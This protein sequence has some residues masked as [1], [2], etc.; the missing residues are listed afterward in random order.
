MCVCARARLPWAHERRVYIHIYTKHNNILCTCVC[1]TKGYLG[2]TSGGSAPVS[3]HICEAFSCR[4]DES[5]TDTLQPPACVHVLSVCVHTYVKYVYIYVC[6]CMYICVCVY[7]YM[8]YIY[9]YIHVIY[10]YI[11]YIYIYIYI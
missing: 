1:V 4:N 6:A 7:I 8:L 2:P 5:L 11:C 3:H 10:I 9:I